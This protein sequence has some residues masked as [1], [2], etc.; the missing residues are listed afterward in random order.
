VVTVPARSAI[1]YY[2]RDLPPAHVTTASAP[3][4]MVVLQPYHPVL[5]A[6]LLRDYLP[7][8]PLY[9]YWNPTGVPAETLADAGERVRLL[10]H[11][12]VWDLAR[13]D[14]RSASTRR[15]AVRRGLEALQAGGTDVAGL[16]VDD[17]DLWTAPRRRDAAAAVVGSLRTQAGR[18]LSLFVN[19][20]FALWPLRPGISAVLL[21]EITPG[22]VDRMPGPDVAWVE[23]HVLPAVRSISTGG[24]A[25][26]GLSYEP[27]P[28][29]AARGRAAAELSTLLDGVLHGR[30]ALDTWPED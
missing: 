17:L 26:F 23:D 10:G 2:G 12:P 4:A 1:L 18:P 15:F 20:G 29:T 13:L 11:D 5:Q 24:A 7:R 16:F 6:G 9:I 22:L 14:L 30:R 19:R 21:E 8:C 28:E 3:S 25:V 27:G